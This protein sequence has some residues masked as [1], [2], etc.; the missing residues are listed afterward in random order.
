MNRSLLHGLP[1]RGVVWWKRE[2]AANK[3]DYAVAVVAVLL[4]VIGIF[5]P[6][7]RGAL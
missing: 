6:V 5:G 1:S 3:S 4:V 7:A 2:Y